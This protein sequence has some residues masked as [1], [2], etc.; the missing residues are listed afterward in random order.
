MLQH[1][2]AADLRRL[3]KGGGLRMQILQAARKIVVG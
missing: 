1:V 2:S 3:A